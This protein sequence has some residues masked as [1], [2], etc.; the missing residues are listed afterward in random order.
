MDRRSIGRCV[1]VSV[2]TARHRGHS[3][4]ARAAFTPLCPRGAAIGSASASALVFFSLHS[5][6]PAP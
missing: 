4:C 1:M 6:K 5:P 3:L 2:G